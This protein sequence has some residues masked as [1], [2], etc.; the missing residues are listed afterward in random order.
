MLWFSVLLGLVCHF[1]KLWPS[2]VIIILP[3]TNSKKRREELTSVEDVFEVFKCYISG[4]NNHMMFSIRNY[5]FCR[6][7]YLL[8]I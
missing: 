3:Y 2:S 7:A 6:Q 8:Q 4:E 1:A 5:F